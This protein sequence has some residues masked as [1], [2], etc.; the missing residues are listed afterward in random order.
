MLET[1]DSLELSGGGI[2]VLDSVY[3]I[4][5]DSNLTDN[6][7]PSC[8]SYDLAGGGSLIPI[9]VPDT[10]GGCITDGDEIAGGSDPLDINDPSPLSVPVLPALGYVL[11]ASWVMA[12][13]QRAHR[14]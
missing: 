7:W 1:V 2:S 13:V 10:D 9:A 4:Y 8:A 6:S 5:Y 14:F 3:N 11:L 12:R